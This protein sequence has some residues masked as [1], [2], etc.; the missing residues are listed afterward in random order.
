ME[1]ILL[2]KLRAYIV[3]NNPDL[4][5]QLQAKYSVTQFLED[6]VTTVMPMV[7]RLTAEGKPA[8]VIEELSLNEMTKELRPSKFNFIQNVLETEFEADYK[9]LFAMGV[10]TCET[11]NILIS[12]K[13]IFESY[14]FSEANKD[15]RFLRYA[16]I[17]AI[18]DYLN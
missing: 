4:V 14:A 7:V 8:H 10:L 18:H 6:K 13:D 11:V 17:A 3:I 9:R 1:S 12:C 15:N 5:E 16:I 2:E